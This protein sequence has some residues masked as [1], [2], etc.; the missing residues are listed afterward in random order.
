MLPRFLLPKAQRDV[1]GRLY[2]TRSDLNAFYFATYALE[3]PRGWKQSPTVG[4]YWRAALVVFFNYGVD[5]GTVSQSACFHEQVLWRHVSWRPEPPSGQGGDSRYG[6]LYY[7]RV[8]TKKQFYRP[9]NR[10]V[11][12][13]L[14]SL[15]P[16]Q[17][18]F[19]CGS[20]R[21]NEQFQRLCSLAD[22][23]PKQDIETGEEKP[24]VLKDLRKTC[25]TY[26][27]EHMPESSIEI[28]GHSVGGVTYRRYAHRD[29]LAFKAIM[30][31]SQPTAFAALSQG[32]DGECPCC[33]RRFPQA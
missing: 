28:L 33:R 22:V 30:S 19:G 2:L 1:A 32:L 3:R 5:T 9:M 25:A 15:C 31:L 29:P 27:D 16:D 26:Y 18:V 21:P 7:R 11:Q 12:T 20:S 8:K 10:V 17:A 13:H 14:K 4:H 23:Q 6:W 24:W